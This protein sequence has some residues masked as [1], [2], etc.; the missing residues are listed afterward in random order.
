MIVLYLGC[1]ASF[2]VFVKVLARNSQK[3]TE[4][5]ADI[6]DLYMA[7]YERNERRKLKS[8]YICMQMLVQFFFRKLSIQKRE[9][10]RINKNSYEICYTFENKQYKMHITPIVGPSSVMRVIDEKGNDVSDII[11]PY[12]GPEQNWHGRTFS[13]SFFNCKTL[14]FE[15][16]D[17]TEMTL[18]NDLDVK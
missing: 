8:C 6:K 11:L 10:I 18:K 13:P 7:I 2:C 12:Y 5:C 14:T 9:A 4:S 15:S 1:I 3:L 16:F 17:G